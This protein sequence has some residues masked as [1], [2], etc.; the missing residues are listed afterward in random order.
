MG[1]SKEIDALFEEQIPVQGG[2]KK[3]IRGMRRSAAVLV[4]RCGNMAFRSRRWWINAKRENKGIVLEVMDP[5]LMD[6]TGRIIQGNVRISDSSGWKLISAV[7]L[8][9]LSTIKQKDTGFLRRRCWKTAYVTVKKLIRSVGK[10]TKLERIDLQNNAFYTT[11]DQRRADEK[12]R[13]FSLKSSRKHLIS[14]LSVER[15]AKILLPFRETDII[16]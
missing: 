8:M 16:S 6:E 11:M 2:G 10:L 3:S 12:E 5:E 1:R 7:T 13:P 15:G 4:G 9:C 14:G